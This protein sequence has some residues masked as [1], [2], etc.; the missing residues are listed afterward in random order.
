M[1]EEHRRD[2][3]LDPPRR[4]KMSTGVVVGIGISVFV[5]LAGAGWIYNHKFVLKEVS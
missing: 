3:L 1:T 2:P 5:H 4:K